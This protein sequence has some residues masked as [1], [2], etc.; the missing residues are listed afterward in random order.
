MENKKAQE[1]MVGFALIIIL[2]SVILLVFLAFSLNKPKTEAT[3]NYE[4]NSFLQSTLQYTTNCRASSGIEKFQTIQNLIF[5]CDL[6]S[7]CSDG[8]DTCKVLNETL[9][10]ILK[11]S[12]PTGEDRPNKGYELIINTEEDILLNIPKGN[13]TKSCKSSSQSFSKSKKDFLINFKVC[14]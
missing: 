8:K 2:V 5:E 12:W 3:E 11:E 14:S 6:K 7:E 13:L 4:V 9:T 1:E 10:D